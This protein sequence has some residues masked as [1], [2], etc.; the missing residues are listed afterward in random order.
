[1]PKPPLL[2]TLVFLLA[3]GVGAFLRLH[4]LSSQILLDDEW[5]GVIKLTGR[6]LFDAATDLNPTDNLGVPLNLYYWALLR[7]FHVSEW[8]ARLPS[9]VSGL[10]S[11]V[12]LPWM[13]KRFSDSAPR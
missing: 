1:M 9:I 6:T 13:I 2:P 5:H 8:T 11:L 3:F 7:F 10:L 4:M 12:L